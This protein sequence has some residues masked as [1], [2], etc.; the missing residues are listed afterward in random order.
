MTTRPPVPAAAAWLGGAGLLPFLSLAVASLVLAGEAARL[1]AKA[2]LAYGAVILSFLGGIRWGLAIAR[3]ADAR[4]APRL[5][6]SVIPS[7]L[8][9]ASLL[10]PQATGLALLAAGLA[11]QL[12][13][14][15]HDSRAGEAPAW[16][17]TLRIPLSLGAIAAMVAG[18]LA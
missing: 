16:Y 13:L 8:G 4:L 14:D 5:G 15:V 3:P 17:P 7:L 18:A 10:L 12:W 1:A 11:A 9:W 6:L 2:L